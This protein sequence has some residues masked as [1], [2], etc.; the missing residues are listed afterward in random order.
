MNGNDSIL[1]FFYY[2][3]CKMAP[4]VRHFIIIRCC[5]LQPGPLIYTSLVPMNM[6]LFGKRA[7]ADIIQ[8]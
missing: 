7:S 4:K 3:R 8:M 5:R 6:A 2:I 1:I